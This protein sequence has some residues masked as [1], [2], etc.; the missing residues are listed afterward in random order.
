VR[1]DAGVMKKIGD[2]P[3]WLAAS[4]DDPYALRTVKELAGDSTARDQR[5]SGVRGHG[6]ALVAADQDL[7]RALVDWLRQTLIF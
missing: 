5:L 6:T 3:V 4:T 7:G 2:R 1:L